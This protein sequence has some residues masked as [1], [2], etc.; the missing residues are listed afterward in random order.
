MLGFAI[1]L[2]HRAAP[3]A[4]TQVGTFQREQLL[5][6]SSLLRL[7]LRCLDVKGTWSGPSAGILQSWHEWALAQGTGWERGP[8][9]TQGSVY[10]YIHSII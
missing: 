2:W 10:T 1:W 8:R 6:R 3:G 5:S 7:G 9:I 4:D